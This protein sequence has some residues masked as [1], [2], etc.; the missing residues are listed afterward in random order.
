[1]TG[2]VLNVRINSVKNP[3][4]TGLVLVRNAVKKVGVKNNRSEEVTNFEITK[5]IER[6]IRT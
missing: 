3:V 5:T 2:K 6:I 4:V 1:M